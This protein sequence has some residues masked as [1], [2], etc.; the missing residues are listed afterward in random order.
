MS[1]FG[2]SRDL[3]SD[4]SLGFRGLASLL[5]LALLLGAA[6]AQA[7]THTW[8]GGSTKGSLWSDVA[9]WVDGDG[10]PMAGET[11]LDLVFPD[12]AMRLAN[13]NDIGDLTIRKITFSGSGYTITSLSVSLSESVNV[14]D[15]VTGTNTFNGGI[16]LT[17]ATTLTVANGA[18]LAQGGIISG[19]FGVTK[20]GAGTALYNAVNTYTGATSV[21]AG[22]L[23]IGVNNAIAS[24]SAVTVA[25]GATLNLNG[26]NDT[27]ASVAGAGSIT[28]GGGTLTTGG[29]GTST[30]LSGVI[31]GSGGSLSKAG[32][33]TFT[34]SGDN[35]YT[36]ATTINGG[37]LLVNGSQPSSNVTVNAGTILGGTG[38]V[39][40][41]SVS[42]SGT[43]SPGVSP[44]ILNARDNVALSADGTFRV[45][46]NGVDV[47]T[48]YD[49]LSV[50]GTG[51]VSLGLSRLFPTL[52][53]NHPD[54]ATIFTIVSSTSTA[55]ISGHF[56]FL[57]AGKLVELNDGDTFPL[58]F[59]TTTC[60]YVINYTSTAVAVHLE[61][62]GLCFE[63]P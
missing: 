45:E 56:R 57:S 23:Q 44:G 36:G 59:G 13:Q 63:S 34:L 18:T 2:I 60:N 62:F 61:E 24:N 29:S 5:I 1:V 46:L 20:A 55:S 25:S 4:P 3:G 43:V 30:S 16:A 31:S 22:T 50:T 41:I 51:G 12:G 52:G 37:T 27:V 19:S 39:K 28:L 53:F 21:N 7:S 32:S 47:G 38:T 58:T 15:G 33:G 6:A 26:N 8:T 40:E 9:N 48:G 11:N 54:S 35:T 17:A 49:R 14:S 42:G 10:A